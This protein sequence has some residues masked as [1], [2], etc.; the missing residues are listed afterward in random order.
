[1]GELGHGLLL[2]QFFML[3]LCVF[4]IPWLLQL[5]KHPCLWVGLGLMSFEAGAISFDLSIP[6]LAVFSWTILGALPRGIVKY[7]PPK[8][9]TPKTKHAFPDYQSL[10]DLSASSFAANMTSS[11]QDMPQTRTATEPRQRDRRRVGCGP[12]N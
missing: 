9:E 12:W 3:V 8:Q 11:C 2:C 7:L 6:V 5:L 4:S 1:M 10:L